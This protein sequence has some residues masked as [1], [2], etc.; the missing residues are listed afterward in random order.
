[1]HRSLVLSLIV[2]LSVIAPSTAGAKGTT[3]PSRDAREM[4]R[5]AGQGLNGRVMEMHEDRLV[6]EAESRYDERSIAFGEQVTVYGRSLPAQ[7]QGRIG[8]V[9]RRRDGRWQATRCDVVPGARIARAL[10]GGA[11]CPAPGVRITDVT[12]EGRTVSVRLQLAGDVT[13]LRLQWGGAVRRRALGPGVT[14]I[15][16][17]RRFPT[18]GR[19]LI[20]VQASGASGPGCGTARRRS[21]TSRRTVD[22]A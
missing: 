7:L 6:I 16:E 9:V 22:V 11:P 20:R 12:V 4:L 17:R 18:A 19:R 2:G 13:D 10:H 14:M 21:A 1:M 15:V 5:E 8:I 3:C